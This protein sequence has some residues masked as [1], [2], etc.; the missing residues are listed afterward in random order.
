[1]KLKAKRVR[2]SLYSFYLDK[3]LV[4]T[5]TKECRQVKDYMS[6]HDG[7]FYFFWKFRSTKRKFAAFECDKLAVGRRNLSVQLDLIRPHRAYRIS[8]YTG[9]KSKMYLSFTQEEY[10]ERQQRLWNGEKFEKVWYDANYDERY[11]LLTGITPE[12]EERNNRYQLGD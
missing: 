9:K 7:R 10:W 6:P 3:T 1:M 8:H 11:F 2:D 5:A 12:Q 4:A